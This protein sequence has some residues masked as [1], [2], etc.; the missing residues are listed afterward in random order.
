VAAFGAAAA[1]LALMPFAGSWADLSPMSRY[2][3]KFHAG[4][5]FPTSGS[6]DRMQYFRHLVVARRESVDFATCILCSATIH[7]SVSRGVMVLWGSVD[8]D[9]TVLSEVEAYGGGVYLHPGTNVGG[10]V[11]AI[12]GP[13]E[14][15]P[16]AIVYRALAQSYPSY[17]YPGQRD[18][19][20]RG[21]G[22]FAL[23]VTASAIFGLVM[24][25]PRRIARIEGVVRD[26]TVVSVA[27]GVGVWLVLPVGLAVGGIVLYLVPVL[28]FAVWL[29]VCSVLWLTIT[30]G[31]AAVC[32]AIGTVAR[33]RGITMRVL[34]GAGILILLMLIPIVGLFVLLGFLVLAPGAAA[35]AR[36]GRAPRARVAELQPVGG[37]QAGVQE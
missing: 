11:L 28:T 14:I 36:Y 31:L 20:W 15:D 3:D 27:A 16:S 2:L 25:G 19:Y 5:F 34:A 6:H 13:A 21:T 7:G 32:G 33:L 10:N 35:L 18:L 24:A 22:I 23:A 29:I 37:V 12:G 30:T 17:Y 8:V 9:G 4:I 1:A 26:G